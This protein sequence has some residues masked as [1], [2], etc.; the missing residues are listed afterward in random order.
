MSRVKFE[1]LFAV[2]ETALNKAEENGSIFPAFTESTVAVIPN[3]NDVHQP[4]ECIKLGIG[5]RICRC[6]LCVNQ[7]SVPLESARTE[8]T[9]AQK[10]PSEGAQ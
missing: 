5:N 2:G 1:A 7:M 3:E 10:M 8:D 4:K 6:R 9:I